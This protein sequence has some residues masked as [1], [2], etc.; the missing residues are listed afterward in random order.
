[1]CGLSKNLGWVNI[2]SNKKQWMYW[3][4]HEH[5]SWGQDTLLSPVPKMGQ[6]YRMKIDSHTLK[7]WHLNLFDTGSTKEGCSLL[8]L[9]MA[10]PTNLFKTEVSTK[11]VKKI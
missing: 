5:F 8:Q 11:K 9:S 6:L 3:H 10:L 7:D 4:C 1:M 2:L